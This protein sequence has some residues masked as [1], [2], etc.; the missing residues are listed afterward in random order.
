VAR[1]GRDDSAR[2]DARRRDA[3]RSQRGRILTRIV[4]A[5]LAVA[6]AVALVVIGRVTANRGGTSDYLDG[7]RRG[8]AEGV[9]QGRAYQEALSLRAG[10]RRVA[11][12]AFEAG[13]AAGANDVFDGYDGG[14]DLARPYVVTLERGH[15]AITYRIASRTLMSPGRVY[16]LC[17]HAHAVC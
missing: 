1:V 17:A 16:R 14:W 5:L 12:A 15:G 7:L 11:R 8:R 4:V 3:A 6:A 2:L 13:Y 9:E 10:S